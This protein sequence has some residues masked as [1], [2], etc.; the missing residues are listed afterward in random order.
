MEL[1]CAVVS[2]GAVLHDSLKQNVM[3]SLKKTQKFESFDF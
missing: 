1:R 3:G 2:V